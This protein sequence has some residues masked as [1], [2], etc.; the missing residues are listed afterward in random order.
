MSGKNVGDLLNGAGVSVGDP[1]WGGFNLLPTPT[2]PQ[3][4]AGVRPESLEQP[5]ITSL[6]MPGSSITLLPRIRATFAHYPLVK[7]DAMAKQIMSTTSKIS[8]LP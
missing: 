3:D 1:L 6:T 8:L 7:S 5:P 4:A 2:G